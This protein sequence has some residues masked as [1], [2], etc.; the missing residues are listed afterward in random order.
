[1]ARR[2][3]PSRS[4]PGLYDGALDCGDWPWRGRSDPT[5]VRHRECRP[6][7]LTRWWEL[8][9][10]R[11]VAV[12]AGERRSVA[13]LNFFF[14]PP[15]IHSPSPTNNVR[16]SSLHAIAILVSNVRRAVRTQADS[17]IA[18]C[19]PRIALRLQPQAR[20][21]ATLDDV[22]WATRL[23]DGIDAE[24]AWCCCCRR[25]AF[26]PSR[27]VTRRGSTRQGRSRGCEL[28]WGNDA[29]RPRLRHRCRCQAPVPADAGPDAD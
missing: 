7:F 10:L 25:M 13:V 20:G 18:G 14:L 24:V 1:V 2:N 23:P 3:G 11:L 16:A 15:I 22:L 12:V 21:T 6:V 19:G 27:R 17:A 26:W 8:R 5:A 9:S 29:R 28:A 4:I